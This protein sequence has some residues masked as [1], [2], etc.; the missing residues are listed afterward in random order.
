MDDVHRLVLQKCFEN[1]N[2]FQS[3]LFLEN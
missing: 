1:W 2:S 3:V